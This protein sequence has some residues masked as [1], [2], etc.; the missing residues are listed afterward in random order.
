MGTYGK[1]SG[2]GGRHT[3]A[4]GDVLQESVSYGFSIW[5]GDVGDDPPHGKGPWKFTTQGRQ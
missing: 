2:T 1:D 4:L 3:T 5:F